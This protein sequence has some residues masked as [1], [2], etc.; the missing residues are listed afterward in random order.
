MFN[1]IEGRDNTFLIV[2]YCSPGTAGGQLKAGADYL[3]ILGEW[4]QVNAKVEVMD[5]FS[6]HGDRAEMNDVLS[7]QKRAASNMFLVHGEYDT[8]TVFKDYLESE[9]YKGVYIPDHGEEVDL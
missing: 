4:K 3:K 7:N 1:N 8:Q 9:A 2:G 6:A 5:S